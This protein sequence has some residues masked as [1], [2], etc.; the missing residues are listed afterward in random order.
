MKFLNNISK[1]NLFKKSTKKIVCYNNSLFLYYLKFHKLHQVYAKELT[2][3]WILLYKQNLKIYFLFSKYEGHEA[4]SDK[5][6]ILV[7]HY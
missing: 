6:F 7:E 5:C 3:C 2:W 4:V 1:T